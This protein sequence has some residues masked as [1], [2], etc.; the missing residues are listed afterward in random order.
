LVLQIFGQCGRGHAVNANTSALAGSMSV[1]I[2]GL[3][4]RESNHSSKHPSDLSQD[5]RP[6]GH[7]A[8][9]TGSQKRIGLRPDRPGRAAAVQRAGHGRRARGRL[10]PR[11]GAGHEGRQAKGRLCGKLPKLTRCR[12]LSRR[13]RG[14]R[15]RRRPRLQPA[16][17]MS[18]SRCAPF[19]DRQARIDPR[20][21]RP[22]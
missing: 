18:P 12:K 11:A 5:G 3:T 6:T 14:G 9:P 22:C 2:L 8:S 17:S 15:G 1:P 16:A 10:D 7:V 19:V 20:R 4:N 21:L 13:K